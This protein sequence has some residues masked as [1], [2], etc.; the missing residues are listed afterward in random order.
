GAEYRLDQHNTSNGQNLWSSQEGTRAIFDANNNVLRFPD[1]SFWNMGVQSSGAEQDSGALYPSLLADTNGN[2]I[3]LAYA[4][5]AGTGG[6]VNTSA[7]IT[8]IRDARELNSTYPTYLMQYN[9]DAIPHLTQ[10]LGGSSIKTPEQYTFT[11]SSVPLVSPFD[12]SP[13]GATTLLQSVSVT[14]WT[15]SQ[16]AAVGH[17]FQYY[18]PTTG[19]TTAELSQ[20]TTPLGGILT[21]TYSSDTY[22][23]GNRTYREVT[24]RTMQPSATAAP[25]GYSLIYNQNATTSHSWSVLINGT[26]EKA[27]G[28]GYTP[29]PFYQ[30]V[31]RYE[32]RQITD[33]QQ[34][35]YV[36]V[37]RK[38]LNWLQDSS[39]TPYLQTVI[40]D[41]DP[42]QTYAT[43]TTSYQSLDQYG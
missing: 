35:T 39:G 36:V 5:G 24:G 31:S 22:T 30:L 20:V 14:G 27:W 33:A 38:T 13:F 43:T 37:L 12:Q 16:N 21:W 19:T 40:T 18:A 17:R 15:D 3:V 6:L 23:S 34:G 10:I 9:T 4:A 41:I 29:G 8:S 2:W 26:S 28:F 42:G 25:S 32:E 7:R 1:G 11:Y